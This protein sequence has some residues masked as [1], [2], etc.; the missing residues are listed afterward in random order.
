MH[1]NFLALSEPIT[2]EVVAGRLSAK[3]AKMMLLIN[4]DI[5]VSNAIKERLRIWKMA[6]S[7]H[8]KVSDGKCESNSAGNFRR[9]C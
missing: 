2:M 3:S 7:R 4:R 5:V 8:E 9:A 6:A 1:L